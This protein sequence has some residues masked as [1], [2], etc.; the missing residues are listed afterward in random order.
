MGNPPKEG[1]SSLLK[2]IRIRNNWPRANH[3]GNGKGDRHE[4]SLEKGIKE[5]PTGDQEFLGKE[6]KEEGP[7]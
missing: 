6:I 5:K 2:K 4:E 3:G 1:P 7:R